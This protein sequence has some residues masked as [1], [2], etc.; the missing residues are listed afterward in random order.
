MAQLALTVLVA[1]AVI[2]AA[3]FA[4]RIIRWTRRNRGAAADFAVGAYL[5]ERLG[6]WV[7]GWTDGPSGYGV[8]HGDGGGHHDGAGFHSDHGGGH[9]HHGACDGGA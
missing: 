7:D 5:S 1:V 9:G 6:D 2:G 3:W 8:P 4:V